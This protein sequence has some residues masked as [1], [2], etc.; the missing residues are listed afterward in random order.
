MKLA[1][2]ALRQYSG[3][4]DATSALENNSKQF[5]YVSLSKNIVDR[6]SPGSGKM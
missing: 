6:L 1:Q 3:Q 4:G 2:Y 5:L